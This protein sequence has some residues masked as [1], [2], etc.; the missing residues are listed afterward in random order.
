MPSA[1][2][3]HF[4]KIIMAIVY[5][6]H[7]IVADLGE[8]IAAAIIVCVCFLMCAFACAINVEHA[9][10]LTFIHLFYRYEWRRAAS[11]LRLGPACQLYFLREIY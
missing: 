7:A 2:A 10:A 4:A 3:Y 9:A 1:K 6:V 5:Q 8:I 11:A